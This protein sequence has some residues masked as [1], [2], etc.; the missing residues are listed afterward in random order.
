MKAA[1]ATIPKTNNPPITATAQISI[2]LIDTS[3]DYR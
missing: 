3:T 1:R 2:V